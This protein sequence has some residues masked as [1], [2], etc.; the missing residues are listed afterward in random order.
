MTLTQEMEKAVIVLE[1]AGL[2]KASDFI[3]A[4]IRKYDVVKNKKGKP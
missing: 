1:Q 2:M 3:K 4:F